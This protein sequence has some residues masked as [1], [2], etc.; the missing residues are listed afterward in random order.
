MQ[1]KFTARD[2]I[3]AMEYSSVSEETLSLGAY[4]VTIRRDDH[5]D[6]PYD[7]WDSNSPALWLSLGQGMTEYGGADLARFFDRV[8]PAWVSRHWRAI[9]SAMDVCPVRH[10]ND[11]R[12][13]MAAYGGR[14]SHWRRDLFAED[15][16]N[17]GAETWGH[18][19]DYLKTL[20]ALYRL[21]GI[22]AETFQRNGYCQGD[23]VYGLIV[24]TPAW[25]E[26][27]GAPHAKP[28]AIDWAACDRDMKEQ[29]D[30][31][32]AWCWG[33][34]YGFSADG[35]GAED[36]GCWGFYGSD[37]IESGLAEAI[38]DDL[39]DAARAARRARFDRLKTWI[40]ARVPYGRRAELVQEYPA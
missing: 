10:D 1:K 17:A 35:P 15:L 38:A 6:S 26:T 30:A 27:V 23:S 4:S 11:A 33:D 8:T 29:A 40:R 28:G 22:P 7:A 31:F 14:L 39:N 36:A 5:A 24:M 13:N 34:V 9:C 3:A 2:V 19:V 18:G 37:P 32:G 16:D 25:A 20:R 21:A 12:A